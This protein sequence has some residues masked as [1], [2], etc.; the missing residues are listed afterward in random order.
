LSPDEAKA[1]GIETKIGVFPFQ[2][3]GRALT[4]TK[5][6]GFIRVIARADNHLIIG[7]QG[8]GDGISEL[9][10]DF[11]LALEMGTRLEDVAG[12]IHPHPTRS[13]AFLEAS[14]RALGHAL[15]I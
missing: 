2:A 9:G 1:A 7:I 12:T 13:E 3:N 4:M 8:V 6:A 14:L 5:E 11:S 10:G 15:H